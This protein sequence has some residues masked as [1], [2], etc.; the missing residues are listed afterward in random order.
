MC[1]CVCVCVCTFACMYA[2]RKSVQAYASTA[3]PGP[4]VTHLPDGCHGWVTVFLA[5]FAPS[6]FTAFQ[7]GQTWHLRKQFFLSRPVV[8]PSVRTSST[9]FFSLLAPHC[10]FTFCLAS[11]IATLAFFHSSR[12][13]FTLPFF[14]LL[15]LLRL[16]LFLLLFP[17]AYPVRILRFYERFYRLVVLG[18]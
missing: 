15:L 7:Q 10:S 14:F 6:V 16:L 9:F 18:S 8:S 1:V 17:S 11:I 4:K 12:F 3:E 2:C 13:R 5:R